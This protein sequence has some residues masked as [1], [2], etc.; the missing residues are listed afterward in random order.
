MGVMVFT[1]VRIVRCRHSLALILFDFA[2]RATEVRVVHCVSER[3]NPVHV[4][5][6]NLLRLQEIKVDISCDQTT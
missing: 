2:R 3:L 6:V 5:F 4:E 1:R